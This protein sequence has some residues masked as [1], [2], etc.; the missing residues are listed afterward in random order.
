MA[1]TFW[2]ITIHPSVEAE[3]ERLAR[4]E[5]RSLSNTVETLCRRQLAAMRARA[6]E[7]MSD[8][9]DQ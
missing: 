7:L 2:K 1:R 8:K 3:V 6:P 5:N 4:I 9:A